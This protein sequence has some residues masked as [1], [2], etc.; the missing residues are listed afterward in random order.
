MPLKLRRQITTISDLG[1]FRV[2]SPEPTARTVNP[3][4]DPQI[5]RAERIEKCKARDAVF[6]KRL[7][8]FAI[9]KNMKKA[10]LFDIEK[11]IPELNISKTVKDRDKKQIMQIVEFHRN[12]RPNPYKEETERLMRQVQK[13][14]LEQKQYEPKQRKKDAYSAHLITDHRDLLVENKI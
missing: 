1:T 5:I 2:G 3:T 14:C 6:C 13:F 9:Y 11:P 4:I 12:Y 10:P 8:Q 7:D